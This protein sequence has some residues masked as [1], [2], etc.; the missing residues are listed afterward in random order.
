V[1]PSELS[2]TT[3]FNQQ[4]A[5]SPSLTNSEDHIITSDR[6]SPG[7]LGANSPGISRNTSSVSLSAAGGVGYCDSCLAFRRELNVFKSRIA[8]LQGK[9]GTLEINH[10]KTKREHESV[11]HNF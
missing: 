7:L 9:L 1:L 11:S 8:Q 3:H 4:I 6:L 2:P 10:E 5:E